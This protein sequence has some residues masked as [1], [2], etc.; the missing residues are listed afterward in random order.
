M[1]KHVGIEL[2]LYPNV[3]G[4][5]YNYLT[6]VVFLSRKQVSARRSLTAEMNWKMAQNLD[7]YT[8]IF[9]E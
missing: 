1:D 3:H 6:N 9:L 4:S 5:A 7:R 8:Y 2:Y